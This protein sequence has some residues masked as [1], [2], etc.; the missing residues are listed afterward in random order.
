MLVSN[1]GAS[2]HNSNAGEVNHRFLVDGA[3]IGAQRT[4]FATTN[5][6]K[7]VTNIAVVN[8]SVGV[9]DIRVQWHTNF[10]STSTGY[11]KSAQT[12]TAIGF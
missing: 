12:L 1:I 2:A 5:D 4:R 11:A 10:G 6:I 8:L 7:A 9:H 3:P